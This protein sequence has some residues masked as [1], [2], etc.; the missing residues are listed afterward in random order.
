MSSSM[1]KLSELKRVFEPNDSKYADFLHCTVKVQSKAGK[2][3][4]RPK[5]K[6]TEDAN[7]AP[8]AVGVVYDI[9]QQGDLDGIT[10][11]TCWEIYVKGKNDPYLIP[12][13]EMQVRLSCNSVCSLIDLVFPSLHLL[14]HL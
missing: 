13:D 6:I 9:S 2:P 10:H 11:G 8:R 4:K 14:D 1:K 5:Y 12:V 3:G 7:W